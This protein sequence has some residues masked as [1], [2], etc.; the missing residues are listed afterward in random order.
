[1]TNRILVDTNSYLRLAY[2]INPLLKRPFGSD[3]YELFVLPEMYKELQRNPRLRNEFSWV[4][5]KDF[6][7]NRKECRLR[8]N[9][10]QK[11]KVNRAIEIMTRTAQQTD[12]TASPIDIKCL[13]YG[14]TLKIS[15]V[16]DDADMILLAEEFEVQIMTTLKLLKLM[17]DESLLTSRKIDDIVKYWIYV[18]DLPANW[19]SQFKYFFKK[20]PPSQM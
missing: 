9:A 20:K 8:L 16:T 2:T 5:E 17:F 15:V 13:A 10:D 18:D 14:Y 6:V 11:G 1:M 7:Q 19:F 3:R 4:F 12:N